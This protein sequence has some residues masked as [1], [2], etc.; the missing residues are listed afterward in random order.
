MKGALMLNCRKRNTFKAE[1]KAQE[2]RGK[3]SE[4]KENAVL[5]SCQCNK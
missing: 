5:G 2:L 4:V 1:L 3:L